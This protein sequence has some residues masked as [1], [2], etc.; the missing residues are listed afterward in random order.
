MTELL[1]FDYGLCDPGDLPRM[2]Y[3]ATTHIDDVARYGKLVIEAAGAGDEVAREIL[4]RAGHELGEC[5]L[6]VARKLSLT[7]KEFPVAYVGG[8]FNAGEL[9]FQPMRE[10]IGAAAPRAKIIR[11]LLAP[12]EGAAMMAIRAAKNPRPTR[13]G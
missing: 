1:C 11:P 5:V 4:T 9:L 8:A 3:A 7:G 12:T 6:A 13:R 10:V 2:V